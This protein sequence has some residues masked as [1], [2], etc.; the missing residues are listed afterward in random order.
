MR[1]I[2]FAAIFVFPLLLRAPVLSAQQ[3]T[4]IFLSGQLVR[5]NDRPVPRDLRVEL[6]CN[7][8]V[9]RQVRPS[10]DGSFSFELGS[11]SFGQLTSD[12]RLSPSVGGLNSSSTRSVGNQ[13]G[14]GTTLTGRIDLSQCKISLA[15]TAGWTGTEV[16]L[17][18][19]NHLDPPD[20]GE[21]FIRRTQEQTGAAVIDAELLAAPPEAVESFQKARSEL[22][23]DKPD[24]RR[25][26]SELKDA[27]KIYPTF[28]AAWSLLGEVQMTLENRDE[29]RKAFEKALEISPDSF[30]PHFQMAR[31]E[32]ENGQ[33][34][35]AR[36]HTTAAL[37]QDPRHPGALFF[38]G[39]ANYYLGDFSNAQ[40]SL[41]QLET[42]GH[43]P[44]YSASL[45]HLGLIYG[46]M[47]NVELASEKLQDYLEV[48]P[49][50]QIP[51]ERRQK[52]EEQLLVWKAQRD[53]K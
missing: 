12:S 2:T 51:A 15:P 30:T 1:A 16:N 11:R 21:I 27:L 8:R 19:R 43:A 44:R 6:S 18:I 39:L 33:W 32:I 38:D 24:L 17:G 7:G 47:G 31:I 26:S 40:K 41:E 10:S 34:E 4:T 50:E 13:N 52:I 5:E 22:T 45:L 46:R 53:G 35:K 3:E 9:V 25:A 14:F 37:E 29:A 28:G 48:T 42:L 36:V 49:E 20:I 23:R